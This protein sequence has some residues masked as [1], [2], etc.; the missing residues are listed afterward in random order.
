MSKDS[1]FIGNVEHL[2]LRSRRKIIPN[3]R[4]YC[5]IFVYVSFGEE[6]KEEENTA[7]SA[8]NKV[9]YMIKVPYIR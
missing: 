9:I 5:L 7:N 8:L 3:T 4:L 1:I 2:F 6:Q